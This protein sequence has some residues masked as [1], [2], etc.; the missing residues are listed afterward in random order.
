GEV[1]KGT[2]PFGK[3]AMEITARIVLQG[4]AQAVLRFGK[5]EL[6]MGG[7]GDTNR[8][9]IDFDCTC[10]SEDENESDFGRIYDVITDD[11]D[12]PIAP[13]KRVELKS[14]SMAPAK[15]KT[16]TRKKMKQVP[17]LDDNRKTPEVYCTGGNCSAC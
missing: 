14:P 5:L 9:E 11:K 12:K 13:N 7:L 15:Q 3:F 16:S 10:R 1:N 17:S 4:D 2:A 8:Y 6:R